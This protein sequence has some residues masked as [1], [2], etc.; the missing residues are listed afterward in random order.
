MSQTKKILILILAFAIL[1]IG[2]LVV[3]KSVS[4]NELKTNPQNSTQITQDAKNIPPETQKVPD[5][6]SILRGK[7]T[8]VDMQQVSITDTNKNELKLNIP[9]KGVK[10]FKETKL[11]EGIT[12]KEVGLFDLKVDSNVEIEYNP[13]TS[14]LNFV[15]VL[16]E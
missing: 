12:L 8:K 10:F 1:I 3:A 9:E 16:A 15:K 5:T 2:I 14:N 13:E 7:I 4:K 6:K 11:K